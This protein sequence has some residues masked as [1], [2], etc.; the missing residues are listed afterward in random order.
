MSLALNDFIRSVP[1]A[2]W[3]AQF[4][5]KDQATAVTMLSFMR[6]VSSDDFV[7]DIRARVLQAAEETDGALAL[8]AERAVPPADKKLPPEPLFS[9]PVA[10]PRRAT[11]ARGMTVD[12]NDEVGSEG[13]VAQ[14]IT[15]L[16]REDPQKFLNH[17]G[18]D[19]LRV[20][21]A[22]GGPKKK[23]SGRTAL[24]QLPV[25][26]F[27]LLT[28][29]IGSGNRGWRYLEAAWRVATIKS[30]WSTRQAKGISFEVIAYA[31]TAPGFEL[32][33]SHATGPTIR[34]VCECPTIDGSLSP[35]I[36][37]KVKSLCFRYD[38]LGKRWGALGFEDTGALIAFA[39][40]IPNNSPR[41]FWAGTESWAPLFPARVTAASRANFSSELSASEVEARLLAMRQKRLAE[42]I[43]FE[44]APPGALERYLV[45]ASLSRPPRKV[46]V[47]ARRT[48]LTQIAVEDV[49]KEALA[50]GWID[51]TY[52]LTDAGH[53]ELSAAKRQRPMNVAP[54]LDVPLYYPSS[55]RAPRNSSS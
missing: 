52:C 2:T 11:G 18:P 25:R 4:D 13:I 50:Y 27:V 34:T 40:G 54:P 23:G 28:D 20:V 43:D 24:P 1:V 16:N 47:V 9:Q 37:E 10:R 51:S 33:S 48:G 46:E 35:A 49:L 45:L 36:A 22:S 7:R 15:E 5:I 55:L 41:V 21:E 53:A 44:L 31:A 42:A 29:I 14:L 3:L 6:R 26:K 30:L 19:R 17:P 32:V 8:Y 12:P 38:P 39:H